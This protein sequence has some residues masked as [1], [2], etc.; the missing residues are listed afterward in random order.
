ME[1]KKCGCTSFKTYDTRPAY[2]AGA[3]VGTYRVKICKSCENKI[4]TLEQEIPATQA[5][6][7]TL[8]NKR[9]SSE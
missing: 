1:C 6:K 4:F 5:A 2:Q 3:S 9:A 7:Y 8:V